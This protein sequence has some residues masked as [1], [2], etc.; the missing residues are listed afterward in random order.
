[1]SNLAPVL[2]QKFTDANGAPLAGGKLYSY[3]AGT[4][5]PLST[6]TD[7]GGSTSNSNPIILDASG[8]ADVWLGANTY[9]FVLTDSNDV[10]QWTI[11]NV[12][13]PANPSSTDSGWVKHAVVDGQAATDL[14]GET[15]DFSLYSSGIYEAEIIRGTTVIANGRLWVQNLNGTGRVI[16]GGFGALEAHGVSFSLGQVALVV[17]LKAALSAG[18]GAGTIKLSRRLVPN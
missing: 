10:V 6:Y 1:L 5:T 12:Q 2:K 14:A 9:K 16:T 4:T 15:I 11:D 8:Q 17:T 18:P 3:I 7:S 13:S